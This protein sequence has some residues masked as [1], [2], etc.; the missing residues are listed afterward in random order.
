MKKLEDIFFGKFGRARKILTQ[1]RLA[2]LASLARS[3]DFGWFFQC[4]AIPLFIWHYFY[5]GENG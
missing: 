4:F 1:F 3:H 5:L 2:S